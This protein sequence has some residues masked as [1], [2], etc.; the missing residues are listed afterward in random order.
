MIR[1]DFDAE[2]LLSPSFSK[3]FLPED[4]ESSS[5]K[6]GPIP[7]DIFK[8]DV[9][10]FFSEN[11]NTSWSFQQTD[12]SNVLTSKNANLPSSM[13][14]TSATKRTTNSNYYSSKFGFTK[15]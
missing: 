1:P 3:K 8:I 7:I 2:K 12:S 11:L 4:D 13:K 5:V 15:L 14:R 6:T 9:S 10:K